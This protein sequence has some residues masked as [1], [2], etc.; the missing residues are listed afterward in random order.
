MAKAKKA[1]KVTNFTDFKKKVAPAPVLA[2]APSPVPIEELMGL[3]NPLAVPTEAQI[4]GLM[5]S[6]GDPL[7][8]AFV[9]DVEREKR[10]EKVDMRKYSNL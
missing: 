2:S 5:K 9:A 8:A 4:L 10:G 6:T 1:G 3:M 7:L